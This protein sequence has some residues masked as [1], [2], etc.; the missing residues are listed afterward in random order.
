MTSSNRL[1]LLFPIVCCAA[2]LPLAA[3]RPLNPTVTVLRE[4]SGTVPGDCYDERATP[5]PRVDVAELQREAATAERVV[6]ERQAPPSADLR[7]RVQAVQSALVASDRTSFRAALDNLRTMTASYPSGGEREAAAEL[8]RIYDDAARVWTHQF[9][10]STGSFFD[11]SSDVF[12][13]V[14]AY[15]GY[16]DA[17]RR[18]VIERGGTRFYPSSETRAFLARA[19]AE[20]ASRF[21]VRSTASSTSTGNASRATAPSSGGSRA[22]QP[23]TSSTPRSTQAS[24]QHASDADAD[25]SLMPAPKVVPRGSR[26]NTATSSARAG[27]QNRTATTRSAGSSS[28][29][30]TGS[31][32]A[33]SGSRPASGKKPESSSRPAS[34]TARATS[35][36]RVAAPAVSTSSGRTAPSAAASTS[37]ASNTGSSSP[38]SFPQVVD[39]TS[40]SPSPSLEP[41][42]TTAAPTETATTNPF[43]TQTT[44]TTQT[45]ESSGTTATV[46]TA[47][48][49]AQTETAPTATPAGSKKRG[50]LLPAVVVLITIA[51]LVLLFR[52]SD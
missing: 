35:Q 43:A 8:I 17:I 7:G 40:G 19:A 37:S 41:T 39:T 25:E 48:A 33:A 42:A 52:A 44:A 26:P 13:A 21:G 23:A 47:P 5:V 6:T 4:A 20:R 51:V 24:T 34:D 30:G 16:R 28:K 46:D 45:T 31:T 15:P 12:T 10:S 11:E 2:A 9:E 38:A 14:N 32:S 49:P 29:P 36:P 18:Q 50:L 1:L 3:Q 27:N 22:T